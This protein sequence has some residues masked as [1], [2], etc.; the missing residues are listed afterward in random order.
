VQVV[1]AK[2]VLIQAKEHSLLSSRSNPTHFVFL[3]QDLALQSWE[4]Y[5]VD[6]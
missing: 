3:H 5:S 4:L 1:L 6:W 2:P